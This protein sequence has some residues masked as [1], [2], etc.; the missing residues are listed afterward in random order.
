MCGWSD[1]ELDEGR[2]NAQTPNY[3]INQCLDIMYMINRI[4]VA[5]YYI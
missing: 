2:Q 4:N 3:K 5:V 1:G